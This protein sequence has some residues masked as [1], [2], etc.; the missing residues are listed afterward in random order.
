MDDSD[1][2]GGSRPASVGRAGAGDQ[3]KNR[4]SARK[5]SCESCA[6]HRSTLRDRWLEQVNTDPAMLV[7]RGK[8][9]LSRQ[10]IAHAARPA[11]PLI[12]FPS[13]LAA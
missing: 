10:Q 5:N 6:F 11:Q 9:E 7:S 2:I 12:E 13:P 1:V 8:C 3:W 4:P